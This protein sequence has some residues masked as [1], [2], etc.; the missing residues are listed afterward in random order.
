MYFCIMML[1]IY[2]FF[3]HLTAF[4]LKGMALFN[5]KLKLF[6]SGRKT[7]FQQLENYKPQKEVLWMHCASLGEFEQGRPVLEDAQI[8]ERYSIVLT[9]FSPSGY[10]V[11]KNYPYADLVLYLPLDTKNK[12]KKFISLLKPKVAIFVKYE[13]W[14]NY[15]NELGKQAIQTV[16]ISGIFKE[17]Q[18]LFKP[19]G[20]FIRKAMQHFTQF[21]VQDNVSKNLLEKYHFKPIKI[22]GD[23]RFD[24]VSKILTQDNSLD[25]L[26]EFKADKM[27]FV[28][29]ST[30]AADEDLI[31]KYSN[32]M[33]GSALK[34]VLAPHNINAKAIQVLKAN[35]KAK[36][37]L[38]S[39]RKGKDLATYDILI[40]DTIGLLSKVYS[41]ADFVY[42]GGGFGKA[43]I[44]NILEPATFGIPIIIAPIF[45]TF[46]E[47]VDLVQQ[48]AVFVIKNQKEFNQTIQ[49]LTTDT[50]LRKQ[51]GT[52]C[53]EY[54][55]NNS[56]A[57]Q[58]IVTYLLNKN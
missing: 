13:I 4:F 38:Y 57:T 30:W 58:I 9:F 52:L 27:L 18:F 14:P 22:A 48:N 6:V 41:Y 37:V 44:H 42:V 17:N 16:L 54:I 20:A 7:V 40:L 33:Q 53:H 5:P 45:A 15:L 34:I 36:T 56:G 32:T 1:N 49:K 55:K 2:T 11:Q 12:A 3:V 25:F 31:L 26:S 43:G 23:T 51:K 50:A 8:Q 35:L 24:R 28:A 19:L 46:K 39:E 47:A 21:F 10:E 29:G